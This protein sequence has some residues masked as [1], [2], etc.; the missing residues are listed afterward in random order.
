MPAWASALARHTIPATVSMPRICSLD[1]ICECIRPSN[2]TNPAGNLRSL[3]VRVPRLKSQSRTSKNLMAPWSFARKDDEYHKEGF[4]RN[5]VIP[6]VLWHLVSC[7][8]NQQ[9]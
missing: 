6:A 7:D 9:M 1:P 5:G 3:Q 4:G 2:S 8:L